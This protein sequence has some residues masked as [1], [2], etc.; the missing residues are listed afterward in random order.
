MGW[1]IAGAVFGVTVCVVA[2]VATQS[3]SSVRSYN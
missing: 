3:S 1:F 2:E